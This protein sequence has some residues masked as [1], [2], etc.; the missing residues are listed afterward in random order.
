MLEDD[1]FEVLD[2]TTSPQSEYVGLRYRDMPK[3]DQAWYDS[4]E[5]RKQAKKIK[6]EPY[7]TV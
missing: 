2:I 1:R 6:I 3:I 5:M 7:V 4:I